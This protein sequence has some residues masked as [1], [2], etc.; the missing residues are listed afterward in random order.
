MDV[1]Q[2][3]N[4]LRSMADKDPQ[5]VAKRR[6]VPAE[7]VLGVSTAKIRKLAATLQQDAGLAE[8]LW[9]SGLHEARILAILVAPPEL[10]T[11]SQNGWVHNIDSWDLSDH[12][13]K[14]VAEHYTAD[15]TAAGT[16]A[17][18]WTH[19]DREL[20][21]RA[22]LALLA[23]F[24]MRQHTLDSDAV[25]TVTRLISDAASDSRRQVKQ[26]CCWALREL[27]KIDT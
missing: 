18:T 6:G 1:N 24:C 25:T 19:D 16:Y 9:R 15:I 17:Q 20:V 12:L 27:G 26:A 22:G 21:R 7:Q 14:R 11:Q 3:L 10:F 2:A 23:N 4:E 13:A 8:Q 5:T